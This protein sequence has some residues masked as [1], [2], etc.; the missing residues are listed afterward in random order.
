MNCFVQ[1][2]GSH[3]VFGQPSTT[4]ESHRKGPDHPSLWLFCSSQAPNI[5][6][7][8]QLENGRPVGAV[9]S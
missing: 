9:D 4:V 6:E 8:V 7:T 1:K 5:I 2:L 3:V